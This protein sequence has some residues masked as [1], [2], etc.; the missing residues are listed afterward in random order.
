MSVLGLAE[1]IAFQRHC[2]GLRDRDVLGDLLQPCDVGRDF[3]EGNNNYTWWAAIG[4]VL[5]PTS[6]VEIGTRYGYSIKALLGTRVGKERR[7]LVVDAECDP[8]EKTL[9][10][11]ESYFRAAG[12]VNIHIRR[13]DSQTITSLGETGFDIGT[14]DA[15]HSADGCY[16]DCKLVWESLRPRGVMVVDDTQPGGCVRE[17]CERFCKE[18]QVDWAYLPSLRGIHLMI[19]E[20]A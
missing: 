18:H 6:V 5:L 11:F 19:K 13:E 8:G 14:V 9:A 4:E 12:V 17:G 3:T 20:Q 10:T 15:L 2:R 7:L 1:A 16:H